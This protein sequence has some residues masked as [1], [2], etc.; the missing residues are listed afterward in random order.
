MEILRKPIISEKMT[1]LGE[2]RRQ[3]AFRV[4]SRANK[5]QIRSAIEQMYGVGIEAVNTMR[6]RGD[7]KRRFTKSGTLTGMTASYKKAIVTL[8]E[9]DVI[10]F[11]SNI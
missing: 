7:R 8:K 5:I 6:C 2:K 9:G 3:Y 11:Y 1:V 4:D 10:D